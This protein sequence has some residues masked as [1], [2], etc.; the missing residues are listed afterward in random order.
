VYRSGRFF[1]P[2]NPNYIID[3]RQGSGD[4]AP[5]R[6]TAADHGPVALP[7]HKSHSVETLGPSEDSSRRTTLHPT[8]R[9]APPKD[10]GDA[11]RLY[12]LAADR[13]DADAQVNLGFS[14]SQ[15]LGGL[16]KDER[17]AAR[18]YKLAA[19]QGNAF[20]QVQLGF[21]YSQGLGG[22][23]KDERNAARLYELAADQG[24]AWAEQRNVS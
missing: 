17:E 6:I 20:A 22:L 3:D 7:F 5:E 24:N 9:Y 4:T 12:K 8:V 2:L 15:G 1:A 10:E 13:G 21:F 19:D 23:A 14:Y 18:L 11:A 16:A